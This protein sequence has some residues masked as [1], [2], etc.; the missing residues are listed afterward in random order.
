MVA[1]PSAR[2]NTCWFVKERSNIESNTRKNE[3]TPSFSTGDNS[4]ESV[5]ALS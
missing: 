5:S 2:K 4:Q 1:G 3:A